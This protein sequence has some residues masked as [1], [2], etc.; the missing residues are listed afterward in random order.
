MADE[1][2]QSGT[3]NPGH[4]K[5]LQ[6]YHREAIEQRYLGKTHAEVAAFI[7]EKYA[8]GRNVGFKEL[9]VRHWFAR[10]GMLYL[11]YE[12]YAKTEDERRRRLLRENMDRLLQR[13]PKILEKL[14]DRKYVEQLPDGSFKITNM[15]RLDSV[16]LG[17]VRLILKA[18]GQ[19]LI[20]DDDDPADRFFD[21]LDGEHGGGTGS[22][23]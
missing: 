23:A 10:A 21:R 6:A 12:E 18:G 13:V 8:H 7:S 22:A 11:P 9:T 19:N 17:T 2:K 14:L 5:A 4:Q 1:T 20:D 15:E 16:T 3:P